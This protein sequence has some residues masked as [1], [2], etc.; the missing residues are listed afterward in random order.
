[1]NSIPRSLCLAMD[2]GGTKLELAVVDSEGE[3]LALR[4]EILDLELG[5]NHVIEQMTRWSLD[6]I[7]DFPAVKFVGISSCGPLDPINGVLHDATNLLTDGKGWGIVPLRAIL[8]T[9]LGLPTYLDNDAA[10]CALA[11]RWLG[12][13]HKQQTSNMMVLTLGTGLGTGIICN[14]ELFRSG[15]FRHPEAGH[16]IIAF[17]EE[18]YACACGVRGDS[19]AYLSGMNFTKYYN[20][21]H[22]LS[23]TAREITALARSGDAK[24]QAA[25]KV[26]ARAMAATL[27]NYC[28][29]FCPEW[30]VFSGSFSEAFDIFAPSVRNQLERLLSRR[31]DIVPQ[32]I[33]SELQNHSCLLG[34]AYLCFADKNK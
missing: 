32:L 27:H 10:C 33:V 1:M 3:I 21:Q 7:R 11:E 20:A 16:T 25:F 26:Y 9:N 12:V 17:D 19:E 34:A 18:D 4:K 15:G 30:I 14:G 22:K 29:I 2:L 24:A 6:L 8:E 5:K 23:L 31:K 28:V 13:G